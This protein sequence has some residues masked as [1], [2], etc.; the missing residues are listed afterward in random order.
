MNF[1][2]IFQFASLCLFLLL[3]VSR[4]VWL[5]R[6]GTKVF[7]IGKGKKGF[8]AWMEIV[9]VLILFAWVYE[10][11]RSS[12]NLRI[13]ILPGLLSRIWFDITWLKIAGVILITSGLVIFALAL[14]AFGRSW[15]IGIDASQPGKLITTGIFSVTRNPVFVFF[16][17]YFIGIACLNPNLFFGG[18]AFM[19]LFG[20]HFHI[21]N[22]EKFLEKHYG[23]S[24]EEYRKKT[25]R[26]F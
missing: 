13:T 20:I 14:A 18:L 11:F 4:S 5:H 24:Y 22:E 15:R 19:A 8:I 25:R 17:L 3:F 21:L 1:F 9:F 6:S 10:I 12:F 26:Y 2:G 23:K 7:V 16:N